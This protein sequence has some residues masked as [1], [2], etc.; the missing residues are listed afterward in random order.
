M[1]FT[2]FLLVRKQERTCKQANH[3]V[4]HITETF[5]IHEGLSNLRPKAV[6]TS[7]FHQLLYDIG[8]IL[9]KEVF[10]FSSINATT[11]PPDSNTIVSK[12]QIWHQL[13]GF[14][15]RNGTVAVLI[16]RSAFLFQQFK[17][18]LWYAPAFSYNT[19]PLLNRSIWIFKLCMCGRT[20]PGPNITTIMTMPSPSACRWLLAQEQFSRTGTGAATMKHCWSWLSRI[21][22]VISTST[23]QRPLLSFFQNVLTKLI[24][25]WSLKSK[26]L[27]TYS[28]VNS[29][30]KA[31]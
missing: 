7:A 3:D 14:P 12:I 9:C 20:R 24:G 30:T 23:S 17:V 28:A 10:A 16:V 4:F 26:E 6:L 25:Y 11:S 31:R 27:S 8:F 13:H 18:P 5:Q 19:R 22:W 1:V 29:F 21:R 15:R 2:C